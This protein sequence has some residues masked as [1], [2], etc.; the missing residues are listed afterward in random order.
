MSKQAKPEQGEGKKIVALNKSA[1]RDF[2]ILQ[3]IEAGIVLT[4]GEVKSVRGG[5]VQLK[6]SYVRV[7]SGEVFLVGCHIS[8]YSHS[9]N[10]KYNP[11]IDRKLLLHRREI[12]RLGSQVQQKGLTLVPLALYLKGGRCK[13]EIGLGRGKKLFDK[14]QDLKE[15]Q[16][17]RAMNRAVSNRNS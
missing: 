15:R 17:V 11:V 14:R 9:P 10:E 2:E 12:D 7:K 5:G 16:A 4:G 6:E 8:P 1:R 3:T 13:L